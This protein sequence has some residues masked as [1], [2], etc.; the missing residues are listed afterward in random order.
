[1][2]RIEKVLRVLCT[3]T[4]LSTLMLAANMA[5]AQGP[6]QGVP[7]TPRVDTPR[8]GGGGSGVGINIDLGA[9]F[10]LI[11]NATKKD[12][13]PK[14]DQT[15][16]PVLQ[17]TAVTVSSGTS[18]NYTIDWV[19]QY[20]NNTGAT[21]PNV[22]VKDGPIAT[23]INPSLNPGLAP[24]QGW[25][26]TTNANAPVDNFALFS[27]TNIAPH[28]VMTATIASSGSG[29]FNV[30]GSG[31]GFQPIPFK[32]TSGARIYIMNHHTLP[33]MTS[34]NCIDAVTGAACPGGWPRQLPFGDGSSK[35]S[36]ATGVNAEYVI[37][38]NKFYYTAQNLS[39]WGIGCFDLEL[40]S[41][42]GFTK[43]GG[44]NVTALQTL[45]QGPWRVGNELYAASYDGQVYCA[46]LAAGLP[47]C[48]ASNYKIPLGTIKLN[49][50]VSTGKPASTVLDWNNGTL[51]GKVIGARLYLSSVATWYFDNTGNVSKY[52]NCFD[53]TTKTAC[54]SS[55]APTKG[56]GTSNH[57]NPYGPSIYSNFV[58]YNNSGA[59]QAIC[60]KQAGLG[61]QD[62]TAIATGAATTLPAIFPNH[63]LRLS[64]DV[65]VW[66]HSY[67]TE[68]RGPNGTP[69]RAWCWNWATSDYCFGN[70]ASI[71][72]LSGA[73]PWDYG[74]N[75]DDQ[76]CI[77]TNGHNNRIWNYDPSNVDPA[78]KKA[79]PCG[80]AGGKAVTIFQPLQ[81]CSG[82][83]PFK[84]TGIEVKGATASNYTKFIVKV[85]DATT[86]AVLLTKDQLPNAPWKTDITGIDAQTINKQL[87]IEIE[88][89]PKPGVT[90]KPYLE[91]RYNAP[92]IE[93]CFKSKHTCEQ[94]KIT[95]I[96]ETPD[97]VKQGSF[98]S[99]KVDV[100]KPQNCPISPPPI[101]GQPG[102]P[103][104]PVCGTATTPA[105]P[106]ECGQPGQ[107]LC[108]GPI[109][110]Q[111]GQP[112]CPDPTCI[113][114]TPGCPVTGS[115]CLP[116][117]PLCPV[118]PPP[119]RTTCLTG[120]CPDKPTQS[121]AEEYKP[122][123]VACVRKEKPAEEPKKA[124]A[125]K[126]RPKPVTVTAPAAP[127]DPNAAP[128]P[129]P[130]P[131][132]KPAAKPSAAN[133]DC[134]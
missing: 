103:P 111:P 24:K 118:R 62:C 95:N 106:V 66:P 42:C 43:L 85:I 76:G 125:P 67:F 128:K 121:V 36:G 31:D 87:K 48:V 68:T 7:G 80:G 110:G 46:V 51:S 105:C 113:I 20:A 58:H 94:N 22:Q 104:C 116:G 114:G 120:D 119:P 63:D 6:V 75:V 93:F 13:Q 50:P 3:T 59:A 133:D 109:C 1:M 16:P 54:W 25:T 131:R 100:D 55:N 52:I 88:Y 91:V 17:K 39:E 9:V 78:T 40:A 102:Q 115:R 57:I 97:L 38:G 18:G 77:W 34:F 90:E 19:V 65:H 30:S 134:D 53:T 21:L 72:E 69:G 2:K 71:A 127:V 70:S 81:Y 45:L 8:Q 107:P 84:W 12:D 79:R 98:I 60:T 117:D 14:D 44:S 11:K 86:N 29:T 41:Q 130:K 101:C 123:K 96:V 49:V 73:A 35:T 129:K 23:I 108:P 124:A 112:K 74:N 89:T 27:G 5:T 47:A 10:N 56:S 28:G 64:L 132:P 33:G 126:P 83:K 26:G 92:P 15:K 82:P 4:A 99:V 32:H 61:G 37:D 122:P